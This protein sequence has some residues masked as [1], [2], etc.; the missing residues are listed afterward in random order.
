MS[1][2]VAKRDLGEPMFKYVANM[3]GDETLG[4]QLVLYMAEY[5]AINYEK[6]KRV[7]RLLDTTEIYLMPTLNPD[8]FE[9]SLIGFFA[10]AAN[11][12]TGTGSTSRRRMN[13]N[14]VD[15]NRDFPGY[16]EV[17][18]ITKNGAATVNLE[19]GRQ[20]ETMYV[21]LFF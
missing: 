9:P 18:A 14:W 12:F 20:P 3:H 19:E 6:D 13:S 11:F 4:R 8:G 7:K 10:G 2:D 16:K 5:L 15:L 17:K 1:A 21:K